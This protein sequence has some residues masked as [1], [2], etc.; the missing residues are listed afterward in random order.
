VAVLSVAGRPKSGQAVTSAQPLRPSVFP[1]VADA[2][3]R[4]DSARVRGCLRLPQ[5]AGGCRRCRH[6]CRQRHEIGPTLTCPPTLRVAGLPVL[7]VLAVTVTLDAGGAGAYTQRAI[8]GSEPVSAHP[9]SRSSLP[10]GN[11]EGTPL[12]MSCCQGSCA[13]P[14]PLSNVAFSWLIAIGRNRGRNSR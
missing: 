5:G 14:M 2:Q 11:D 10:A 8:P 4:S 1:R 12:S 3:L 9:D 6:G 13:C 7:V